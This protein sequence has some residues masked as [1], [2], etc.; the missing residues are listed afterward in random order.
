MIEVLLRSALVLGAAYALVGVAVTTVA[1]A[2]R[3]LHLAVGPILVAGVVGHALLVGAGVPAA[4]AAGVAILLGALLSAL[5]EPLVLRPLAT[6][7]ASTERS[8]GSTRFVEPSREVD[9]QVRWVVGLAVAAAVL[10]TLS[11]RWLPIRELR[12]APLLGMPPDVPFDAA[13]LSAVVF[14]ASAAGLLGA[15]V[16]WT[17][18]GRQLRLVG[19]SPAAAELAG[20]SPGRVRATAFAVSG[21]AAVLAG[22][23]LAPLVGTGVGQGGGLTLRAVAAA[24]VL[25]VG[26]P[27]RAAVAG[28]L[29][30]MVEAGAQGL[31]PLLP[32]EVAVAVVAVVVLCVRGAESVRVWG[33]AW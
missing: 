10:E 2:A 12:P 6:R 14:G 19:G 16:A 29:L 3:T 17:P 9:V 13:V 8:S 23:L 1:L 33:R 28:L 5:L 11:A 26:G 22:M 27:L 21:A 18:W 32:A 30:G 7:P 15:A 24:V 4:T 25:G 20:V 31:I